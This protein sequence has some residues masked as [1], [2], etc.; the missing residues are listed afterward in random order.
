MP[1]GPEVETIRRNLQE[2]TLKKN[3]EQVIVHNNKLRYPIPLNLIGFIKGKKIMEIIKIAKYIVF[4]LEGDYNLVIHLGMTGR[5]LY[6]SHIVDINKH[7]HVVFKFSDNSALYYND[8][9]RFGII[10]IVEKLKFD[11]YKLFIKLGINPLK[12]EFNGNY[13]FETL[14]K[15]KIPIKTAIMNNEI[16]TDIGNIYASESLYLSKINPFTSCENLGYPQLET[17]SQAIKVILLNAIEH[18]GSTFSDY[19]MVDGQSGNF[20]AYLQVYNRESLG[21]NICDTLIVKAKLA[22]RAT[23]FCPKCQLVSL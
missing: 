17:L 6:Y 22:G 20:Q 16:V 1:E 10:D 18:Q 2:S 19:K 7:D 13:L 12:A 21:C 14:K 3:F 15:R 5:L 23:Y 9:R 8:S 11:Q 4:I